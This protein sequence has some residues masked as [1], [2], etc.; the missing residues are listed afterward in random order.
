MCQ[1]SL[2]YFLIIA[3]LPPILMAR[4]CLLIAI[5]LV[6]IS[7][8]V[9]DL[10]RSIYS[11]LLDFFMMLPPIRGSESARLERLYYR[12]RVALIL[13]AVL[14]MSATQFLTPTV[15]NWDSNWYNLSR[16]P[17]MIIERSVFPDQSPSLFQ[18]IHPISHDLLYLPDIAFVNLRGMGLIA[19]ME[20]FIALGSLYSITS[21]LLTGSGL[22]SRQGIFQLALLIVTILF[23]S[24]DLQVLQSADPKNDL[25]ILMA[26]LI[27]LSM[28][29]NKEFRRESPIIYLLSV[30]T[31]IVYA[32]SCKAYGL[33]ALAPPLIAIGFDGLTILSKPK[34]SHWQNWPIAKHRALALKDVYR[35]VGQN[36]LLFTVTIL[37]TSFTAITYVHH[38]RSIVDSPY[39]EKMISMVAEHSNTHGSLAERITIFFLNI[40]RNSVAFILYPYTTLLKPNAL[41]PDDYILG[42][43]PLTGILSD[44]RGVLNGSSIVRT[45]KADAAFG[46]IL[47]VPFLVLLFITLLLQMTKKKVTLRR[48]ARANG[49][50]GDELINLFRSEAIVT[51]ILSSLICFLFFSWSLYSQTFLSKYL[52]STYVPL[53]P[54]LGVGLALLFKPNLGVH[55]IALLFCTLYAVT[56]LGLLVNI[57]QVP[58]FVNKLTHDPASLQLTQSPNLMYYQYAGS[59]Y[60]PEQS[61]RW[62]NTLAKLPVHKT[63]VLCFGSDTATLTPLMYLAQSLNNTRNLEFR[64]ADPKRCMAESKDPA[65]DRKKT[66]FINFF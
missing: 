38:L 2:A 19:S 63:H 57:S 64:L 51:I 41:R 25:T 28:S 20:F 21:Y 52:G 47:L 54:I 13:A 18:A 11:R 27:S 45:T 30:S 65:T 42:F 43:G 46:S 44:S 40:I 14:M 32:V 23:L 16:I 31:V 6:T 36:W 33:I 15:Y 55:S 4:L 1:F 7:I 39:A 56:R 60:T 24:S 49:Q 17:L 48:T 66:N 12:S 5:V 53:I 34:A 50:N 35:F 61:N 29:V 62:L 59:A 8:S 22:K 10:R 58:N 3:G 9:P 26:F 37:V